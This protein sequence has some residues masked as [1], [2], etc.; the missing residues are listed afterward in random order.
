MIHFARDIEE[1]WSSPTSA[2]LL[3]IY[4]PSRYHYTLLSARR[5]IAL[6]SRAWQRLRGGA[7]FFSGFFPS[8]FDA[9]S[10]MLFYELEREIFE[11]A[12]RAHPKCAPQL[13]LVA[14]RVQIWCAFKFKLLL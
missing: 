7:D 9:R 12:A 8:M 4:T 3:L 13:V 14:S 5:E 6:Y 2:D 11:L 1:S 10:V